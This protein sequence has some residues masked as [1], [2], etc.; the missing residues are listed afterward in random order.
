MTDGTR[1]AS[2]TVAVSPGAVTRLEITAPAN[3]TAGISFNAT[4]SAVDAS[5]NV[6]T[7]Y[8]GTVHFTSS[9]PAAVL[10]ADYTFGAGD[11]G[12]ASLP[13]QLRTAGSRTLTV[14]TRATE[15]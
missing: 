4:V 7:G 13:V 15:R 2:A 8:I 12:T 6:A 9:D 3:V 11:Q 1:N 14:A 5:N 10:P